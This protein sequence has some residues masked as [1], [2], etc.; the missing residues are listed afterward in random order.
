MV[1]MARVL[2][3]STG[4]DGSRY[5]PMDRNTRTRAAKAAAFTPTLI[6]AVTGVGAPSYTSGAHMWKGTAATLKASPAAT[7][8]TPQYTTRRR[9]MLGSAKIRLNSAASPARCVVPHTA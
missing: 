9:S 4:T 7:R 3:S 8:A 2:N 1:R 5:R 6:S